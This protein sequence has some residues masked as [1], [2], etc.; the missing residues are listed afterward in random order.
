M[1][2]ALIEHAEHDIHRHQR[3][4]DQQ[5]LPP[6]GLV[7]VAGIAVEAAADAL[8][9]VQF[10]DRALDVRGRDLQRH[11]GQQVERHRGRRERLRVK[12][13]ERRQAALVAHHG[14][15]RHLRVVGAG[16][17]DALEVGRIGLEFRI[18]LQHHHVLVA[19]GIDDRDLPLRE[20]IVQGVVDVLDADAERWRRSCGRSSA[21]IAARRDRGR[22]KCR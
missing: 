21:S 5:R 1:R 9:H 8:R 11:V 13:R 17:E 10:V 12:D 22:W 4:E 20:R 15:Q 7:E 19:L 3:A 18:D 16:D 14:R 6:A 2:E